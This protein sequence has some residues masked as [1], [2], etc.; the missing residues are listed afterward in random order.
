[1]LVSLVTARGALGRGQVTEVEDKLAKGW[2]KDGV[3]EPAP[4]EPPKDKPKDK[5]KK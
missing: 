1:M 5:P 3:A 4:A 2:I